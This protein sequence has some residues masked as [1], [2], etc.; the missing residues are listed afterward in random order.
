MMEACK[1]KM[2]KYLKCIRSTRNGLH[3]KL[4]VDRGKEIVKS[5]ETN[6]KIQK[7]YKKKCNQVRKAVSADQTTWLEDQ[8]KEIE[9]IITETLREYKTR[10]H[11]LNE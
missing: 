4:A 6:L 3:R 8:W 5:S 2:L 1:G 10:Y 11:L 9:H 7:P